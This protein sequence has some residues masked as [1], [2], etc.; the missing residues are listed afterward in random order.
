MHLRPGMGSSLPLLLLEDILINMALFSA[1]Q[2]D[3]FRILL[4]RA[5][6]GWRY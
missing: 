5:D 4:Y 2:G 3:G 6:S 1:E